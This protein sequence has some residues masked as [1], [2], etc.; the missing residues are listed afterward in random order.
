MYITKFICMFLHTIRV[1]FWVKG[2]IA[3]IKWNSVGV[4]V[5]VCVSMFTYVHMYI[6]LYTYVHV[7]RWRIWL[8]LNCNDTFHA[9]GCSRWRN[10]CIIAVICVYIWSQLIDTAVAS[11]LRSPQ[12]CRSCFN[13]FHMKNIKSKWFN[14]A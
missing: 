1:Q 5:V 11:I 7:Y 13:L 3:N 6:H 8:A 2:K 12:I 9:T 10:M 4:A 14:E